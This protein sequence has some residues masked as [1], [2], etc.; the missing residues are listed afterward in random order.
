MIV[1]ALA[2]ICGNNLQRGN[3]HIG[4]LTGQSALSQIGHQFAG[5]RGEQEDR[6]RR[7]HHYNAHHISKGESNREVRD[8]QPKTFER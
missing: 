5:M 2:C 8:L 6:E 3:D 7:D 1:C 4:K